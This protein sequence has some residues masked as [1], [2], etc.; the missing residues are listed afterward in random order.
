LFL[1]APLGLT[2]LM[3]NRF[4][5]GPQ[6]CATL[7]IGKLGRD[8]FLQSLLDLSDLKLR[9]DVLLH[10]AHAFLDVQLLE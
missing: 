9:R 6:I 3:L 1:T 8:I 4:E 5:L 10:C 7:C 2:E